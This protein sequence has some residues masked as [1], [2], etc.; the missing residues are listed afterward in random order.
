M[1]FRFF[2]KSTRPDLQAIRYCGEHF[3]V[4]KALAG[5]PL[6]PGRFGDSQGIR[7]RVHFQTRLLPQ[8]GQI[9][10]E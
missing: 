3:T 6:A 2:K 8:S 1:A 7:R 10:S 9:V 4:G 5:L